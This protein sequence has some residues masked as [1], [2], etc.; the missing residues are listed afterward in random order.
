MKKVSHYL[1]FLCPTVWDTKTTLWDTYFT[2]WDIKATV[3]YREFIRTKKSMLR[4]A[5]YLCTVESKLFFQAF[6]HHCRHTCC[7]GVVGNV[8]G[9][10]TARRNDT[11]VADGHPRTYHHIATQPAVLAHRNGIRRFLL[12]TAC[13]IV[14]GMLGRVELAMR[15]YQRI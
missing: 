12:L 8:T 2:V 14:H 13:H 15:T 6:F 5:F 10:H 11:A 9:Y 1:H 4:G 7:Q 3:W